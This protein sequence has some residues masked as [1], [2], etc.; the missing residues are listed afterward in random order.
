MIQEEFVVKILEVLSPIP[1]ITAIKSKGHIVLYKEGVMFGKIIEQNVLLLSNDNKFIEVESELIA[2][3][4]RPK[5][6]L[7]QSDCDAFLFKATKSWWLAKSKIWTISA[8]K[9]FL[10]NI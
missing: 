1:D 5:N 8:T 3:I 2:R 9:G 7:D 10:E 6:Q 4:L